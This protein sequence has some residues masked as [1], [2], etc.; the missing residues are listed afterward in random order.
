MNGRKLKMEEGV[1]Q[2]PQSTQREEGRIFVN[3]NDEKERYT[4]D[5]MNRSVM[6]G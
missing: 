3:K 2:R 1:S 6:N 5:I 4:V